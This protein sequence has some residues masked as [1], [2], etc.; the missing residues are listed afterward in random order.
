MLK[1][2]VDMDGTICQNKNINQQYYDVEPMD[3]AVKTL[4]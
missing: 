1:I 2:C 4:Y 3:G